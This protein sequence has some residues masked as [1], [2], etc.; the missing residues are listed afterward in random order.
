[1]PVAILPSTMNHIESWLAVLLAYRCDI[2]LLDENSTVPLWLAKSGFDPSGIDLI[3]KQCAAL[4]ERRREQRRLKRGDRVA[5]VGHG[6]AVIEHA[7][8]DLVRAVLSK[9]NALSIERKA[10][11]WDER[12]R[13]W[14]TTR[15]AA[16]HVTTNLTFAGTQRR[17]VFK[18]RYVRRAP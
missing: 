1:V 17:G 15:D 14:E 18:L 16:I 2:F 6:I 4:D 10:V 8:R 12:N 13:R 9:R 5:V 11:V 7:G 3:V